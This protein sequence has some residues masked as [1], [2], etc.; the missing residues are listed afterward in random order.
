MNFIK[1]IQ[2]FIRKNQLLRSD[3][4]YLV[5]LS[6]GADSVALLLTLHELGYQ[7]EACHCN[8]HLRGEESD[9]DELFC[10]H[11]CQQLD[12]PLHRIHFDTHTYAE[13]HKE[14]IELA[15]RNLRYNYFEQLRKDVEA[16][17]IC[18]AHHQDDSVETVLINLIRGTGLQGLTGISPKNGFILRPLLC[19]DRKAILE[20]LAE[21]NQEYV[22][23]STNLVDDVVRNKIRLNIIPM[24][25][26][27]NPAVCNNIAATARYVEGALK[28]L[29]SYFAESLKN[30]KDIEGAKKK[31]STDFSKD[32]R[33]N[34]NEIFHDSSKD[35]RNKK[36]GN[37]ISETKVED[38]SKKISKD[39]VLYQS[40]SEYALYYALSPFGFTGK[41]IQEILESIHNV[42][43]TW[44]S[45]SHRLLI[46][47]ENLLVEKLS[48]SH[49]KSVKMPESGNYVFCSADGKEQ[50]IRVKVEERQEDFV[51][52]KEKYVITLDAEK[53]AF[54]LVLRQVQEGDVFHPF[55]MKGKKLVSDFL[56]DKKKNLFEKERQLILADAS[57]KILWIVGE[58]TS[59]LC[60]IQD[61][62]KAVLRI[63]IPT[64]CSED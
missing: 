8:F 61:S 25:K 53:I 30:T 11:L 22:T 20:F 23:D 55:G 14:S 46:D 15:A 31:V 26:E 39:W 16:D 48:E 58:R 44:K 49:F 35:D 10:A 64:S 28:T 24:L 50:K 19:I 54:P 41:I 38:G 43:K 12:I 51:P 56:T 42:G 4:K 59:E 18:V 36:N 62:T 34:E 57:G 37:C 47:R 40:S 45:A 1:K 21:K 32:D 17:G 13:L 7:I 9:R 52:S 60:K 3:G 6:G 2:D 63:E 5:A 29:D 33:N 27:I